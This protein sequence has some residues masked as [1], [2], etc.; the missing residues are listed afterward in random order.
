MEHPV[1]I[2][3]KA[4]F[5]GGF[6]R[7]AVREQVLIGRDDQFVHQINIRGC[8]SIFLKQRLKHQI[9]ARQEPVVRDDRIERTARSRLLLRE[10]VIILLTDEVKVAAVSGKK[11]LMEGFRVLE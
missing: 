9:V 5:G 6:C 1:S 10:D 11:Y 2:L 4:V 8:L 3:L 7:Q